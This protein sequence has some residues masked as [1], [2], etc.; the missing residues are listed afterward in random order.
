MGVTGLETAFAILHSELVL[1]GALELGQLVSGLSA[2]AAA[3]E[4]DAP[5]LA[6][7]SEANVALC[8]LDAEW[9]VGADGYESRSENSCFEGA[10]VRG[11]VLMTLAA[12]A[13]AYRLRSFSMGV[14]G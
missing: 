8:D 1:P 7:G 10:E 5:S 11:R 3:F 14:A 12:G 13:V 2:G 9:T 4:L 6:P